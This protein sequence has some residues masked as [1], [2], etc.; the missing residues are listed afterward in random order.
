[1]S[2]P[3]EV[4]E[5]AEQV[6]QRVIDSLNDAAQ[7]VGEAVTLVNELFESHKPH[8]ALESAI[9]AIEGNVAAATT[10]HNAVMAQIKAAKSDQQYLASPDE[11]S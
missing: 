8:P 6:W 5:K 3:I 10:A 2:Q 4:L 11:G 1:M 7:D 9:K